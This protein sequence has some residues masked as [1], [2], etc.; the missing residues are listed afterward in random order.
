M[1]YFLLSGWASLPNSFFFP[2]LAKD[3]KE[4]GHTVILAEK[5]CADGDIPKHVKNLE[6]LVDKNGGLGPD[7]VFIG[8]S[9]GQAVSL[10]YLA[11]RPAEQDVVA[12]GVVALGG[13]VK[14]PRALQMYVLR[15]ALAS[16]L[17]A[18]TAFEL[19]AV[20]RVPFC[21]GVRFIKDR[22]MDRAI[23]V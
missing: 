7:C 8:Q 23:P 17:N 13:W 11:S 4:K 20:R 2:K 10:R 15:A 9:Q 19:R 14:L 5:P 18:F 21:Q 16:S 22:T 6:E 12:G 3:L 1:R